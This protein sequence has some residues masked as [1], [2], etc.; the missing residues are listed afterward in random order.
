MFEHRS[1]D[2]RE[3]GESVA[4]YQSLECEECKTHSKQL[5]ED[6]VSWRKQAQGPQCLPIGQESQ[7]VFFKIFYRIL[8]VVLI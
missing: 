5:H 6:S 2:V 1:V 3:G 7:D 8:F 4:P